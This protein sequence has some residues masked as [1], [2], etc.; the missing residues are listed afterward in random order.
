M[1]DLTYDRS[2]VTVP[3]E[4]LWTSRTAVVERHGESPHHVIF[5]HAGLLGDYLLFLRHGGLYLVVSVAL[6]PEK[7]VTVGPVKMELTTKRPRWKAD[8]LTAYAPPA[9]D[10][11]D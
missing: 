7:A 11:V 4:V 1:R 9:S 6:L 8:I 2:N 3:D 10:E 5:A